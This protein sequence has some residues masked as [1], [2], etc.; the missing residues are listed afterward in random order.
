M[1]IIDETKIQLDRELSELDLFVLDFVKIL[2][3]HA[4]YAI[5]S[6]YVA[7]LFGRSRAT[8]DVDLFITRL[9]RQQF[10]GFYES[11]K[12]NGF[13]SVLVDSEEEL[14]SM[15]NDGLAVRF[16]RKGS[17][18]PNMEMKFARDALDMLSL[19]SRIKVVTK[20]GSLFISSPELQVAYKK[21]VLCSPKDLEDARH[22]QKLFT[23]SDENINKYK[24]LFRRYGRL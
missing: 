15:L 14:F 19:Q 21:W 8:E 24:E 11:L 6:G 16:G 7:L 9:S 17:P 4:A 2:E 13:S 20:Q 10:H 5:V 22:L 18:I 3:K 23:I 1:K 12:K